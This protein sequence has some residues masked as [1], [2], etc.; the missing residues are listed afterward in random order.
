MKFTGP[1]HCIISMHTCIVKASVQG[2]ES[3]LT[4]WQLIGANVLHRSPNC[5]FNKAYK[6]APTPKR[7]IIS[8]FEQ[9]TLVSRSPPSFSQ[10]TVALLP[11]TPTENRAAADQMSLSPFSPP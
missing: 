1:H 8:A 3:E 11:L 10:Q 5:H 2:G 9:V 7:N 6:L 4:T